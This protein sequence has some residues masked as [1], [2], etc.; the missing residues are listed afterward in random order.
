MRNSTSAL[1]LACTGLV[2]LGAASGLSAQQINVQVDK[3]PGKPHIAV[4]DF[5]AAGAASSLVSAFNTTVANDLASSPVI[6]FVPKTFYPV[7]IPQATLRS[8]RRRCAVH[9]GSRKGGGQ[10]PDGLEPA[11]DLQQL[12]R[13]WL[14][15]RY[16]WTIRC[17]RLALQHR[18]QYTLA[19]AGSSF[20][21]SLHRIAR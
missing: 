10:S 19:A 15:S 4:P 16:Q 12:S 5:R 14:W 20:R 13:H 18:A 17:L 21:K 11:A 8:D 6:N 7:Q 2:W 3:N 9:C 1:F